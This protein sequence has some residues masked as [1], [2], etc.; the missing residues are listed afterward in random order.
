MGDITSAIVLGVTGTIFVTSIIFLLRIIFG[1][2][3]EYERNRRR[4]G[5]FV[6]TIR[7][8]VP[9][10]FDGTRDSRVSAGIAIDRKNNAWLEQGKLSNEAIAG[11]LRSPQ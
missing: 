1:N 2:A 3:G 10:S 9:T 5:G 7:G 6:K 11:A 8:E 4:A